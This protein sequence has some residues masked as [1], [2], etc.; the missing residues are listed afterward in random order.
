VT[1]AGKLDRPAQDRAACVIISLQAIHTDAPGQSELATAIPATL[2]PEIDTMR[3]RRSLSFRP[4]LERVEDRCLAS[5]HPLVAHLG[6]HGLA[7]QVHHPASLPIHRGHAVFMGGGGQGQ[8]PSNYHDWGVITLWNTTTHRVTF[9]VSASTFQSGRY[10]NFTL[11][12]GSFQSYYAT[13]DSFD[14]APV[15][16]VSFDPI[17]RSDATQLSDINIVFE[18]NSWF[19]RVGTEGRPYAIAIDVSGLF[20]TPI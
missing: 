14:N 11:R 16:H 6:H 20:L 17:H 15:F 1:T 3:I 19:P 18:R 5:V 4:D 2:S 10:F 9:S 12:P 13:F 8:L 7:A